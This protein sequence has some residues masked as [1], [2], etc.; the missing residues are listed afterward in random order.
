MPNGRQIVIPNASH[1]SEFA[2]A[3]ALIVRFV[4]TRDAKSLDATRCIG[5]ARR[6]PFA[7][8]IKGLL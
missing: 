5:S 1:D 4:L 7:T 8:S 2:C 3:D 6:P